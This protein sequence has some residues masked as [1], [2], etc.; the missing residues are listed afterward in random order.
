MIYAPSQPFELILQLGQSGSAVSGLNSGDFLAGSIKLQ[1]INPSG[2]SNAPINLSGNEVVVE[3][4]LT[5]HGLGAYA[6]KFPGNLIPNEGLYILSIINAGVIDPLVGS[7]KV[8]TPLDLNEIAA[9]LGRNVVGVPNGYTESGKITGLFQY[10]FGSAA[11]A[12]TYVNDL[13]DSPVGTVS[14]ASQNLV[15]GFLQEVAT[16]DVITDRLNSFIRTRD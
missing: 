3:E 6:F 4:L 15:Q 9:L 13:Q 1:F 8:A 14:Q 10:F 12:R 7:V 11:D 16:Y 2:T 5:G